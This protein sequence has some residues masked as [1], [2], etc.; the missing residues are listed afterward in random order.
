MGH[1]YHVNSP[2]YETLE[3]ISTDGSFPNPFAMGPSPCLKNHVLVSG[4]PIE[5]N[6][7]PFHTFFQFFS[8]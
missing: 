8:Q 4:W 2:H 7:F 1:L 5:G 6:S 3:G